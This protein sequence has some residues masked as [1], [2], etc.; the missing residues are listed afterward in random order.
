MTAGSGT[1]FR[2]QAIRILRSNDRGGYTVPSSG[3]YPFQWNWDSCVVALGWA[4]VDEKRAWQEIESLFSAQWPDG[5]VPH[6]V[7]HRADP[8]YFPG[9]ALWDTGRQPA[10]SG[11][12]QPP[13][14]ASCVRW[15]Y[16]AAADRAAAAAALERLFPKLLAWHRWFHRER[17]P[18]GTGAVASLHPWETGMDNSPTWDE[19]LMRVEPVVAVTAAERRDLAHVDPAERPTAEEYDRYLTLVERFRRLRYD[20]RRMFEDSPFRV[21]DPGTNA[22]LLRADRDLAALASVLHRPRERSEIES[23]IRLG[24]RALPRW[25]ADPADGL[26]HAFDLLRGS[27]LPARTH[28]GFLAFYAGL[29]EPRLAETLARW[30]AGTRHSLSSVEPGSPSFDPRRYWRGPVWP[31]INFLVGRGL[32]ETGYAGLAH[33]LR[34]DLRD[35]VARSGFREYFDPLTGDGL[36][37]SDFSWTAAIWLSWIDQPL[38]EGSRA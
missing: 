6:I 23:W 18:H 1:D 28:A 32:E 27:R 37:G 11:I 2:E 33:R 10:S 9:P 16:E 8:G 3:L 15:L 4:T 36:G 34:S 5:M 38:R 7:F 35:L 13:V 26:W 14:A 29:G 21:I 20:A 30:M 31:V 24:E 12:T 25:L 19:P 22:I 17:D